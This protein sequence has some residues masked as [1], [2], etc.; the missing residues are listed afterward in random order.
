ML[1]LLRYNRKTGDLEIKEFANRERAEEAR[2][3][4]EQRTLSDNKTPSAGD[5]FLKPDFEIVLLEADSETALRLTHRRY[6]ER[7]DR[8]R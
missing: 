2:R 3:D 6:F 7:F 4:W 1:F 5:R 8:R